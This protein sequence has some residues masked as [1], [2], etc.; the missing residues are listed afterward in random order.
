MSHVLTIEDDADMSALADVKLQKLKKKIN[1]NNWS[2]ELEDL[3][4]SWGEKAAGYRELHD[5]ASGYWKRI[6]DR[7]Y[8]PVIVLSTLGGVSNFG[9]AS[10]DN[11]KFWMYGIGFV[12]IFTAVIAAITQYY[13]PDEKSQNHTSVARNFGSFYRNMTVELGISREDRMNSD[14]LI[15]WA[16]HEYDRISVEAPPVPEKIVNDFKEIHGKSKK[17]L[18]DLITCDY[19]IK[20][21]RP[22]IKLITSTSKKSFDIQRH[23]I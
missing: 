11:S 17:N 20:V 23:I 3:M 13:K 16:K 4:Q 1:A 12:N 9:A 8:L 19:E 21:N 6:G 18:P 5:G 22:P 10:L 7:L 14:D 15:R 2:N